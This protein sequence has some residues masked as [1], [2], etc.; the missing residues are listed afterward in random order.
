MVDYNPFSEEVMADPFPVYRQL[1]EE[2]P[3]YRLR[4]Y[5]CWALSRFEDVWNA[6]MDAKS[7]TVSQGTT[8][9]QL[10][11]KIQPVTPMINNLDPPAH[12]ALRAKFRP[13]FGPARVRALEPTIRE[14]F[15]NA[16][17]RL[18]ETGGGDLVGDM[19]TRVATHVASM[20][21]GIPTEDAE[22]LYGLVQRFMGRE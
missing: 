5:P 11:T 13:F 19:G 22:M 7:F 8:P 18:Q 3:V 20:V 14:L 4:D 2:A 10:L 9:S 17:D 6:S 12:T 16:L 21:S 1:R 15:C